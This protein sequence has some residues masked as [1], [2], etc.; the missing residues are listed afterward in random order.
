MQNVHPRLADELVRSYNNNNN[1]NNNN[2]LSL[3]ND[4]D[5]DKCVERHKDDDN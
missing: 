2:N 1:N 3:N 4:N 5:N